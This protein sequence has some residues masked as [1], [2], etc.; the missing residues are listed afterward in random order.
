[1]GHSTGTFF[2]AV[3]R[4]AREHLT[5]GFEYPNIIRVKDWTEIT[6]HIRK[7]L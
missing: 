3:R 7:N 1:V 2:P 5:G 4:E 6:R